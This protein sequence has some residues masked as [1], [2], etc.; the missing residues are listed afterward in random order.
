MGEMKP[1]D[2]L[3][4]L[5]NRTVKYPVGVLEDIPLMIGELYIPVD[6]VKME[7]E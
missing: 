1:I 2:I 5:A 3:L 6:F 4:Q 7:I